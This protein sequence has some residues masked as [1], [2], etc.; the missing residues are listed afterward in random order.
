MKE[1]FTIDRVEFY[2]TYMQ[3][4]QSKSAI[5]AKRVRAQKAFF[6]SSKAC[7]EVTFHK[8]HFSGSGKEKGVDVQLAVDMVVAACTGAI[9]EAIIMTG[10]ADLKYAVQT[11]RRFSIP[12]HIAALASRYPFGIA[13][14]ATRIVVYDLHSY[15]AS[16]TPARLGGSRQQITV[17]SLDDRLTIHTI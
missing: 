15:F 12:V 11:S 14:L 9:D 8:G 6:D 5:H 13:P 16:R 3:I 2:G 10:D 7:V 17:R 1:D 4:D